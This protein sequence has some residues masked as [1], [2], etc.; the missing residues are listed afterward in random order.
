MGLAADASVPGG[1]FGVFDAVPHACIDPAMNAVMSH[2]IDLS[3]RP[4]MRAPS[5]AEEASPLP[6]RLVNRYVTF[7]TSSAHTTEEPSGTSV[8]EG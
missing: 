5:S 4:T 8:S 2:L 6:P 3:R 7:F 1:G